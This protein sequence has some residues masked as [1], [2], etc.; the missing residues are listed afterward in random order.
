MSLRCIIQTWLFAEIFV[1]A[2]IWDF[3]TTLLAPCITYVASKKD[4]TSL[5]SI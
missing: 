2:V 1:S 5:V 3:C 4:S